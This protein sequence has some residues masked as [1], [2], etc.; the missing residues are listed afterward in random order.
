[1]DDLVPEPAALGVERP[2]QGAA[3]RIRHRLVHEAH[4]RRT[5]PGA[6]E[7]SCLTCRWRTRPSVGYDGIDGRDRRHR[8][9]R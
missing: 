7:L 9:N 5:R 8:P 1:V 4:S 2:Q 6:T 3:L